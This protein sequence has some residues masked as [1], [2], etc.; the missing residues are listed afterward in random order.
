MT[1]YIEKVI[2]STAGGNGEVVEHG[3]HGP[4]IVQVRHRIH[5]HQNTEPKVR[6]DLSSV[7]RPSWWGAVTDV[8]RQGIPVCLFNDPLH[9]SRSEEGY[10]CHQGVVSEWDCWSYRLRQVLHDNLRRLT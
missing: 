5:P 3:T 1:G 4:V 10:K 6:Q 7:G 2:A 9:Q 8:W